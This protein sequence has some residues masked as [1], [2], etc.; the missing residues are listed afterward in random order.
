VS[1]TLVSSQ[2]TTVRESSEGSHRQRSHHN[3]SGARVHARSETV[4]GL[5]AGFLLLMALLFGGGTVNHLISDL[6]VQLLASVLLVWGLRR[7]RWQELHSSQRQ[8]LMLLGLVLVLPLLQLLP[9]PSALVHA[10]PGRD[11]L[12]GGRDELGLSAPAFTPWTLDPNG[13]LAALRGLLPAAA[14]AVL[15]AQLGSGWLRRLVLIVIAIGALMV[16]LGIAQVAQGPQSDLR[17]YTPTNLHDAVGLFANRNHYAALL[18]ATLILVLAQ[19][20]VL[21]RHSLHRREYTLQVIGILLSRSRAG[22]GLAVI[23]ILATVL[24]SF[25]RRRREPQTFRWMLGF[26]LIGGAFAFQFGFLA[27]ADRLGQSGDQRIDVTSSVLAV[28]SDFAWLGTGLGS[29]SA[30]YAAHEPLELVGDKILN[31]AH[32]DWAELWVELGLLL[33]PV[34]A[35]FAAWLVNCARSLATPGKSHAL[36]FAGLLTVSILMLHALV[37]Y[38]LRTTSMS[39]IF[40]LAC[41]LSALP[42]PKPGEDAET[43]ESDRHREPHRRHRHHHR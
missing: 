35:L 1:V 6:L 41:L 7:L 18:V 9:L 20:L 19:P 12:F 3:H 25:I 39:S 11:T 40:V 38:P 22:V 4:A 31:H 30:V 10:F 36:R 37:D 24:V 8:L 23:A 2:A 43:D 29:F 15:G 16:P 21:A 13:T 26:L 14:L 17:P 27:I 5:L 32:N 34:V 42:A 33:L 28:S